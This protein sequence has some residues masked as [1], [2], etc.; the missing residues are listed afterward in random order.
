MSMFERLILKLGYP[1]GTLSAQHRMRPEISALVR[2]LTYPDLVDEEGTKNRPNLKGV[3]DSIVFI[4]HDHPEDELGSLQSIDNPDSATSSKQNTHEARMVL[5]IVQYLGQQGYGTDDLVILTPYL[6][7]LQNLRL[8][9]K[10]EIDP[11]L[12]DLDSYDLLHAG[13][14]SPATAQSNKKQIRIATIG[15]RSIG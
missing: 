15:M 11:V 10:H 4:N 13:L 2:H 6:G 14:T 7:Q 8:F 9:L 1:H 3:R 12:N 5:K